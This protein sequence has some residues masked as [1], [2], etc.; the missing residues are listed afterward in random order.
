MMWDAFSCHGVGP[1]NPLEGKLNANTAIL[2]DHLQPMVNHFYPD[3][4]GHFQD[5]NA[6]IHRA[7]VVTKWFDKHENDIN[8][9]SWLCQSPDLN[10]IE[11]TYGIF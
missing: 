4:S 1:L 3:R 8:H 9:M 7:Q 11:H 5:N 10:P 6:P 2:S